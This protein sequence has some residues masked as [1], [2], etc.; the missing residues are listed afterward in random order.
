MTPI[1]FRAN[2]AFVTVGEGFE[3]TVAHLRANLALWTV[4]TLIYTLVV[5]ALTYAF[6]QRFMSWT[7][8][9]T[10]DPETSQAAAEEAIRQLSENI[11]AFI[12][13]G[14][15]FIIGSIAL[16]WIAMAL[17]VGGLPGRRMT[18]D[19]AIAAG[20][21]T[22]V[23]GILFVG[24]VLALTVLGILVLVGVGGAASPNGAGLVLLLLLVLVP[25]SIVVYAY[26]AARLTFATFAIFD[27]V[28]I[29][30]SL[31]VSWNISRGGVLRILGWLLAMIGLSIAANIAGSIAS[32]PF[33]ATLPIVGTLISVALTTVLQFVQPVVLAVLYESQ[34][35][36]HLYA[37]PGVP[38]LPGGPAPSIHPSVPADPL[39][40]PPPPAW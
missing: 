27:G 37:S 24:A 20:L 4:P 1:P 35:M 8:T 31:R 13:L 26:L 3:L 30:D 10:R 17:A 29:V 9:F 23:L 14:V 28:G 39:Q 21:K 22:I 36:R 11:P 12:G 15:L 18:P 40:P 32:A 5:G 19:I 25:A 33:A 38:S 7:T 16:N 6:A 2:P 34:R